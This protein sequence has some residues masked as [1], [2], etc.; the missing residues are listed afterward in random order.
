MDIVYYPHT[1]ALAQ[2]KECTFIMRIRKSLKVYW[3]D[4][5]FGHLDQIRADMQSSLKGE[6]IFVEMKDGAMIDT[7]WIPNED[8]DESP[9]VMFCNPNGAFYETFAYDGAWFDFYSEQGFNI[10]LWNYRGYGRSTGSISPESILSDADEL[11]TRLKSLKGVEKLLVH[12]MSMGGGAACHLG[13]HSA[14]TAIFADRTFSSLESVVKEE[15]NLLRPLFNFFTFYKWRNECSHKFVKSSKYKIVSCD[16][17]DEMIPELSSLKNGISIEVVKAQLGINQNGKIND[18]YLILNSQEIKLL[19]S[20]LSEIFLISP[21]K[22]IEEFSKSKSEKKQNKKKDSDSVDNESIELDFLNKEGEW[23]YSDG[24]LSAESINYSSSNLTVNLTSF[25][26]DSP[27]SKES[28][29]NFFVAFSDLTAQSLKKIKVKSKSIDEDD[30]EQ[31]LRANFIAD[32]IPKVTKLLSQ[33][34]N[35]LNHLDSANVSLANLFYRYPKLKHYENFRMFLLNIEVWGS[36]GSLDVTDDKIFT[37]NIAR[38]CTEH[39][40]L[41]MLE[42]LMNLIKQENVSRYP[43]LQLLMSKVQIVG[44]LFSKIVS[45][46]F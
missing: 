13:N 44:Y 12:G 19:F 38:T 45:L 36:Y 35:I 41:L 24:E 7:M 9:T 16:P 39:R 2:T 22:I 33:I 11:A 40:I 26:W 25:S 37:L 23:Q 27:T 31:S 5:S 42:S 17:K 34:R 18:D 32:D 1:K 46:K 20:L 4:Q 30:L 29:I 43:F 10:F 28:I 3:S 21:K 6:Q 8:A 15:F 14:V